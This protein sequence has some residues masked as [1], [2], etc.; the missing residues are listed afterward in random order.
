[1]TMFGIMY[2][3]LWE[4]ELDRLRTNLELDPCWED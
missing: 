2:L 1:M 3:V 4:Q